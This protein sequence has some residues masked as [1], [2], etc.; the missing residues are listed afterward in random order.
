MRERPAL[1][2][3]ICLR[4]GRPL[5]SWWSRR[6]GF[7]LQCYEQLRPLERRALVA[8]ASAVQRDLDQLRVTPPRSSLPLLARV[9]LAGALLACRT[10]RFRRGR[11]LDCCS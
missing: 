6:E 5:T 11:T 7:G 8:L 4:C 9:R 1:E 2:F 10:R 3:A